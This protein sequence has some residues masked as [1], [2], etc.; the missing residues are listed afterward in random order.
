MGLIFDLVSF[1]LL[2][3]K[4]FAVVDCVRRSPGEF[5]LRSQLTR[6]SWLL[7]LGFAI[8]LHLVAMN[9]LSLFNLLGTVAALVYLA[10]L[11]GSV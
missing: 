3:V 6:A 10:Q 9:P 1:A 8:L 7:I 5:E 11:R 2:A 4:V